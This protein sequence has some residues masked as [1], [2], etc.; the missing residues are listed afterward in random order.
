MSSNRSARY[1]YIGITDRIDRETAG[2]AES[3]RTDE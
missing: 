2:M 1:R 3:E